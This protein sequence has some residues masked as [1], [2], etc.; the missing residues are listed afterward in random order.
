MGPVRVLGNPW[1]PLFAL[2][3]PACTGARTEIEHRGLPEQILKDILWVTSRPRISNAG[4]A[5]ARSFRR[6]TSISERSSARRV[7]GVIAHKCLLPMCTL[8]SSTCSTLRRWVVASGI[9]P[10]ASQPDDN[11]TIE[12]TRELSIP[13]WAPATALPSSASN[14]WLGILRAYGTEPSLRTA[15]ARRFCQA[16][17]CQGYATRRFRMVAGYAKALCLRGISRSANARFA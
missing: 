14:F 3:A 9:W 8:E 7:S 16:R 6:S 2:F 11:P 13:R 4:S 12:A 1:V 5:T 17:S 15:T 10:T